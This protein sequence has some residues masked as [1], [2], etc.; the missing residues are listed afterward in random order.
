MLTVAKMVDAK[1]KSLIDRLALGVAAK[2]K[3]PNYKSPMS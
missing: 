1:V 3:L 2:E